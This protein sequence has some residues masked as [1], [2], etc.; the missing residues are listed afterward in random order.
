M[1]AKYRPMRDELYED[2]DVDRD[3]AETVGKGDKH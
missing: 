2:I 3:I 1:I